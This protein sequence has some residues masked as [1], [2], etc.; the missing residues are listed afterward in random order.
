MFYPS[1]FWSFGVEENALH[2][3]NAFLGGTR[4]IH[5]KQR[6][7]LPLVIKTKE[8]DDDDDE[9]DNNNNRGDVCASTWMP[10][11]LCDR[12]KTQY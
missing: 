7:L 5:R 9:R 2:Y 11:T 3:L 6:H 12:E 10:T 8:E 4:V 1:L